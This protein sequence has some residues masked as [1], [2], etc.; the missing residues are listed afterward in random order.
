MVMVCDFSEVPAT[1]DEH[2]PSLDIL[3][4]TYEYHTCISC[5]NHAR[6][7]IYNEIVNSLANP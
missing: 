3:I 2:S 7:M 1:L 4:S 6:T 5:L